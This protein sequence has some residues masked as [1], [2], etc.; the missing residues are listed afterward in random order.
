LDK[1]HRSSWSKPA[2]LVID[3]KFFSG[4]DLGFDGPSGHIRIALVSHRL[5]EGES[6]LGFSLDI[7]IG[8]DNE[9]DGRGIL[10]AFNRE[11]DRAEV[12]KTYRLV[13]KFPR[14][15]VMVSCEGVERSQ[16][17]DSV[18]TRASNR[19]L[20]RV[21]VSLGENA[22]IGVEGFRKPFAN[23]GTP[24]DSFVNRNGDLDGVTLLSL[25]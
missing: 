12:T 16:L 24:L 7:P 19:N 15:Q 1:K 25:F 6:F 13:V 5:A 11:T 17:P 23:A 20:T 4:N 14:G 18:S 3:H 21:T 10:H 9:K 8:T 22:K 2:V